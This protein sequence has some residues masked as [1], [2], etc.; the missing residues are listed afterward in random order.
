MIVFQESPIGEPTRQEQETIQRMVR[1]GLSHL[2]AGIPVVSCISPK[3]GVLEI[4][5]ITENTPETIRRNS[6]LLSAH[7]PPELVI[8]SYL[9]SR[10]TLTVAPIPGRSFTYLHIQATPQPSP[11]EFSELCALVRK[12]ITLSL[13][14]PTHYQHVVATQSANLETC[15]TPLRQELAKWLA[16]QMVG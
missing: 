6:D 1:E 4:H 3:D 5:S 15:P 10:F 11:K 7:L 13:L 16:G 2:N 14:V 8:T 9:L 12:Q